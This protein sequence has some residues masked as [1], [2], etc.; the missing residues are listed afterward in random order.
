MCSEVS[1]RVAA[2][3]FST[4]HRNSWGAVSITNEETRE[5][6]VNYMKELRDF[7]VRVL[8]VLPR[9]GS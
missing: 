9:T 4:P 3:V 5:F 8:T 7:I 2:A 6:L 1:G